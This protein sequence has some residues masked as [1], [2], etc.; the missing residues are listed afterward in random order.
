MLEMREAV[1]CRE[2]RDGRDDARDAGGEQEDA[3]V[4]DEL[5]RLAQK[6]NPDEQRVL[7]EV[8]RRLKM[9]RRV[10]GKLD[11]ATDR[12]DFQKE[13]AEEM[14]DAA[15]YGACLALQRSDTERAPP[16]ELDT[17]VENLKPSEEAAE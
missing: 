4:I 1:H 6:L 10:Y 15:V 16:P 13:L 8:A 2:R 11:L 3:T 7:L 12:R 17:A 5:T 9:G 14:T